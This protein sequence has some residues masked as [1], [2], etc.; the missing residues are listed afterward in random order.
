MV[1]SHTEEHGICVPEAVGFINRYC[2]K[3]AYL[4][5]GGKKQFIRIHSNRVF[6]V[7]QNRKLL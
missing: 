4:P 5:A 1:P 2:L 7:V 6:F 3:H